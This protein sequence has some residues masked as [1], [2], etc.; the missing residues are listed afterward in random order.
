MPGIEE[1]HPNSGE[2]LEMDESALQDRDHSLGAVANI[3]AGKNHADMAFDGCFGD[4]ELQTLRG[5][6]ELINA[7]ARVIPSQNPINGYAYWPY[8]VPRQT[9]SSL[10]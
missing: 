2:K 4:A 1:T 5:E 7:T 9:H 3:Q 10:A 6:P 8:S